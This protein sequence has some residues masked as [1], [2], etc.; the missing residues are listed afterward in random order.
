MRI[1]QNNFYNRF[2]FDQQ[3]LKTELNSVNRQIS[4]GIKIKYGYEDTSI[5][6]DTLRLDYEEHSLNQA[7]EVA[8][9]AQNFANHTD[10]VMFQFTDAL[11]RFKTL[12]VQAAN[13][14]NSENNFYAI[15][16]ELESLKDNIIN[17]A[18][19]SINGRYLF[20]GS[21]LDVKPIDA[22]GNYQGND[23]TLKAVVG[24]DIEVPYNIPGSELFF[25]EDK[26]YNRILTTNIPLYKKIDLD[27]EALGEIDIRPDTPEYATTDTTLEEMTGWKGDAN[28]KIYFYVTGKDSNGNGFKNIIE[29]DKSAN[30][31]ELLNEIGKLYGNTPDNQLVNVTLNNGRIEIK[32]INSGRSMIDFSMIASD[33]RVVSDIREIVQDPN[34]HVMYFNSGGRVPEFALSEVSS[35]KNPA[36]KNSFIL[37]SLFIDKNSQKPAELSTRL[38]DIF[39]SDN[40]LSTND[41]VTTISILGTDVDG[42]SVTTTVSVNS[43]NTMQDLLNTISTTFGINAVLKDNGLIEL[44]DNSGNNGNNFSITSFKTLN[45]S[46][47]PV[48]GI[49]SEVT[50]EGNDF[51]K[52]GSRLLS[53]VSHIV[54]ADN[55]YAVDSTKVV[56][57]VAKGDIDNLSLDLNITDKDGN[58]V[59]ANIFRDSD[60]IVKVRV[61][62]DKDGSWDEIFNVKN[63]DGTD[64]I[65]DSINNRHDF[66][67][68]QLTD[69]VSIIMSGKD[70]YVNISNGTKTYAEGVEAA[71]SYID[72]SLDSKGRLV[73]KDKTT[74]NTNMRLSMVD[75]NAYDYTLDLNGK[76]KSSLFAFQSNNS[77]VIDDPKHDFF[78]ALD[79]AIEAVRLG[80]LRPDGTNVVSSR[81]IGIEGAMERID[82]VLNHFEKE[83]TKIGALSNR[84]GYAIERSETLRVNVQTLRSGILDTDIAEASMKLNQLT[85]NF[86]ALYS[87]ITKINNLSLVNYMK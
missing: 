1:T 46:N 41:D 3:K 81:N 14:S 11:I 26:N 52:N 60:K 21:A 25:G 24:A 9:D 48:V 6:S 74:T 59:K 45:S 56:D 68:R 73:V 57:V 47:N 35:S 61:D 82:H 65:E 17:L 78:T 32:D 38:S 49:R 12:L 31:D 75:K 43:T 13:G 10:S 67:M 39:P 77:I 19:S 44:V 34:A 63:G 54:K 84:L 71:R 86:Q 58:S 66:T 15:S 5:F 62:T 27:K 87:T 7:I 80:R 29:F 76:F 53:E 50:V 64:T 33:K 79:E 69:I 18:N 85:L 36:I 23:K 4:S 37:N 30:I 2:V 22:N 70:T 83:H 20:S 55:S 51:I 42:N 16:N 72:T 40:D 8:K 28:Q